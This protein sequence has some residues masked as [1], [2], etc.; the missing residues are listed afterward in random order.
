MAEAGGGEAAA[1]ATATAAWV[2]SIVVYPVKSCRGISVSQASLTSNGLRWD[3]LWMIVNSKGRAYTQRVDPK[4]ALIEVE[5]PVEAFSPCWQP[6]TA[7]FLVIKAPGMN[8]VK[9][10]MVEPP[11][12]AN[13]VSVW[14]WTGS[15]FDE[16]D[17]AA[18]WFSL[19]LGKPS[20][21]VRFNEASESRPSSG[22][23][24]YARS[25]TIKFNDWY[26]FQ[27][28][29]QESLNALND[30]LLEPIKINRF[31]AN[32]IVEG[33]EAFSEDLW[34][35]IK[36]NDFTFRGGELCYRC[37]VPTVNQETAATGSE[38]TQTLSTFRSDK[39][40]RPNKEK[41]QGRVYMGQ[42]LVCTNYTAAEGRKKAIRVG[43]AVHVLKSLSSYDHCIL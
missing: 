23:A 40:L 29:S 31:R 15:A 32:F 25:H 33:C 3:R 41:H 14:E 35:E 18:D 37:K 28:I 11:V 30:R 16:G 36:I 12:V 1:A 38:P 21:L 22:N 17:E 27:L 7:S 34:N 2:K 10:P 13:G 42:M 6:N 43:D 5:L 26:P 4:L 39:V 24:D 19:F 20:R 8:S 9:I